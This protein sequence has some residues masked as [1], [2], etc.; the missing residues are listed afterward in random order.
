MSWKNAFEPVLGFLFP[1]RCVS[2]GEQGALFCAECQSD[3]S[4][5]KGSLPDTISFYPYADRRVARLV[6]ALKYEGLAG[7][8]AAIV[9]L[10]EDAL[11][12][13]L[14][15]RAQSEGFADPVLTVVPASRRRLKLYRHNHLEALGEALAEACAIAFEPALLEMARETEK[16]QMSIKSRDER[17]VNLQG[18]FRARDEGA[19]RAQVAGRNILVLDDVVTTGATLAEARRALME[20]GAA[21]VIGL[22][23][24]H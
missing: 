23:F 15:S 22:T 11:A 17:L 19:A 5:E 24:A 18:A 3:L 9:P 12:G 14:A 6:W 20:A 1:P 21:R 4:A 8:G 13:E 2:C 10:M 7:A 16:A